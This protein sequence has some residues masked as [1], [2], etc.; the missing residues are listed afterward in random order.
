MKR[1][2]GS[3]S[4][5]NMIFDS[6]EAQHIRQVL[7]MRVGDNIIGQA[8]DQFDYYCSI[9]QIS[10]A[11]VVAH[12]DRVENNI[13][14]PNKDICLFIA[15]PKREYFETI[16]TKAIELG[17]NKIVPFVSNFS[18]NHSFKRERVE[19]IVLTACK[20]CERSKLVRVEDVI[21]FDDMLKMIKEFDISLFANEHENDTFNFAELNNYNKIAVI[22]GCEGG[23]SEEEA[24]KIISAGAKSISLGK[25]ILRCDT[26]AVAMLSLTNVLSG[27]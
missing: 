8:D 21:K 4:G 5:N 17:V 19:Q 15:M 12:I 3:I 1:F 16:I 20:Q 10:K 27:N 24:N 7:R 26:A 22:V 25:R 13:A 23:F 18:V 11:E 14:L 9:T 6:G 2:F